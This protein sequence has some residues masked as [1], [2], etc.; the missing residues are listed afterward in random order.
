VN[1]VKTLAFTGLHPHRLP[2]GT[3]EDDPRCLFLTIALHERLSRLI[4]GENVRRFISGMAMGIDM[5]CAELVLELKAS[6]PDITLTAA[7]PNKE[8]DLLWPQKQRERYARILEQ[9]DSVHAVSEVY[10]DDC[11][12][13]RNRWI[14]NECDI[15]LAV[16]DGKRGGAGSTLSYAMELGKQII[17]VDSVR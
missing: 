2:W 8:Q 1:E 12:E 4:E 9:C 5:I 13:L 11:M 10:T 14:A 7:I 16:W 15:L 17:I 3:N 6:Y